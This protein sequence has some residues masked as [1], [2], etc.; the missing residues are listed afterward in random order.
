MI[1]R[2]RKGFAALAGSLTP[3]IV[4]GLLGAFGVHVDPTVAVAICT[5][6]ATGLTIAVP[7]NA[8]KSPSRP[9]G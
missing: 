9:T 7:A 2:Y 3:A 8:A 1:A 5:V 4:I 6:L